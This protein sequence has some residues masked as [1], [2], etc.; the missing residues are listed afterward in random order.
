ML[1]LPGIW[2]TN[3]G[4]IIQMI[5]ALLGDLHNSGGTTAGMGL[6]LWGT[7]AIHCGDSGANFLGNQT[8][9]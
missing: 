3:H 5:C 1:S 9:D 7:F 6:C 2:Q 8:G 4:P